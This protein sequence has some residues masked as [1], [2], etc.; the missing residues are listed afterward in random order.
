MEEQRAIYEERLLAMRAGFDTALHAMNEEIA[1]EEAA[2]QAVRSELEA[3]REKEAKFNAELAAAV[4]LVR[5]R[6][7]E[8]TLVERE[9]ENSKKRE[10][11]FSVAHSQASIANGKLRQEMEEAEAKFKHELEE[12]KKQEAARLSSYSLARHQASAEIETL[13]REK[14][15]VET[16]L[17]RKEL[18]YQSLE[19]SLKETHTLVE[20]LRHEKDEARQQYD[21]SLRVLAAEKSTVEKKSAE[22]DQ[23]T[24][25]RDNLVVK[26]TTLRDNAAEDAQRLAQLQ[27]RIAALE[28]RSPEVKKAAP[29][30]P[31]AV[32]NS[33]A[34]GRS[35]RSLSAGPPAVLDLTADSADDDE[36][37]ENRQSTAAANTRTLRSSKQTTRSTPK[38]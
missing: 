14:D 38:K 5:K 35:R 33:A 18:A 9:L 13:R 37:S 19:R 4:L 16:N 29:R 31:I 15:A 26:N 3:M 1:K 7:E 11:D 25:E 36:A 30:H 23:L 21:A 8:L 12:V 28:A 17:R 32:A 20:L 34:K 6:D 2:Q 27:E 10:A 24:R 22:I